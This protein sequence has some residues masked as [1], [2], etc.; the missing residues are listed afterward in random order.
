VESQV[1][2][3]VPDRFEENLEGRRKESARGTSQEDT[4]EL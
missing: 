1:L 4:K 3:I 2:H